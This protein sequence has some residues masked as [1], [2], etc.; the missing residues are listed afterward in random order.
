MRTV[1]KYPLAVTDRQEITVPSLLHDGK[2]IP[3]KFLHVAMQNG[4]P[5]VWA[6]VDNSAPSKS[7]TVTMC[8]TGCP[9]DSDPAGYLGTILLMNGGLVLRVFV[10]RK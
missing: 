6:L 4:Q 10:G 8:G 1:Y 2:P 3:S 7:Y 5:C 9:C